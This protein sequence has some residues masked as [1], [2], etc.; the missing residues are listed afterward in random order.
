MYHPECLPL[1][2]DF[3]DRIGMPFKA[4]PFGQDGFLPGIQIVDGAMLIDPDRLAGSG[5]V[6]HEAGHIVT[7]P[8]RWRA[9][10]GNDVID[11]LDAVTASDPGAAEDFKLQTSIKMSEFMAQAWSYAALRE[12]GL[13]PECVFFPG[14]YKFHS[15]IRPHPMAAWVESGTHFGIMALAQV[16]M[17]GGTGIFEPLGADGLP[18]FPKMAKWLQD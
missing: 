2:L 17:T 1:I 9:M 16:G 4:G 14:S 10:L 3:L 12:L 13:P 11:S 6:L 8:S 5:D 18:Q 15:D 7:V